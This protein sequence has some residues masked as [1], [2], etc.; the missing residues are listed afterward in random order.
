MEFPGRGGR[1]ED[2]ASSVL[3]QKCQEGV[4]GKLKSNLERPN[5]LYNLL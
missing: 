2:S 3:A 1:E 5:L 4:D